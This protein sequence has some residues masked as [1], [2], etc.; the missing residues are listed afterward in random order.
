[1]ADRGFIIK[2]MLKEVGAELNIHPFMEGRQQLPT[3]E[4]HEGRR[5]ASIRIHVERAL[6]RIKTFAILAHTISLSMARIS[7]QIVCVFAYLSNFKTALVHS[8]HM[9]S[10][11]DEMVSEFEFS[12]EEED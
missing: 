2:E 12:S 1:M 9:Y 3:D 6:G 8:E 5:I 7:N 10:E 4:I 11:G